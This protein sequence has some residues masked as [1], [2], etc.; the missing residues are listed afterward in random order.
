MFAACAQDFTISHK[1]TTSSSTSET[2]LPSPPLTSTLPS[3]SSSFFR[4]LSSARIPLNASVIDSTTSGPKTSATDDS[5]GDNDGNQSVS[6]MDKEG[7]PSEG[8]GVGGAVD[9][10]ELRL[11]DGLAGKPSWAFLGSE[12]SV[13]AKLTGREIGLKIDLSSSDAGVTE[14]VTA[15]SR[16]IS[17][18]PDTL[19]V[20]AVPAMANQS[21]ETKNTKSEKLTKATETEKRKSCSKSNLTF[22]FNLVT[23]SA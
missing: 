8:T 23:A 4:R 15:N 21:L 3:A 18:F 2:L 11:L 22:S 6:N 12:I 13:N 5:E 9:G 7:Q 17:N 19:T 20:T 10:H 16:L 1:K 14:K